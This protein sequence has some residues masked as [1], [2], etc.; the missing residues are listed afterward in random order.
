VATLDKNYNEI[1]RGE[2]DEFFAAM[3]FL[4]EQ[5]KNP[6]AYQI[7]I[8]TADGWNMDFFREPEEESGEY[9]E[10]SFEDIGWW[11]EEEKVNY[12]KRL[13]I[14]D[15]L[16]IELHE[17]QAICEGKDPESVQEWLNSDAL[18]F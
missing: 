3:D 4:R 8:R 18:P 17:I 14:P 7:H 10:D 13:G 11:I 6:N 15:E 16:E 5:S 12:I 2:F 9:C 1:N